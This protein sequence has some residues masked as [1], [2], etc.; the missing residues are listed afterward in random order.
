MRKGGEVYLHSVNRNQIES[1]CKKPTNRSVSE[2]GN[3]NIN[4]SKN[5]KQI[6]LRG[7]E[8]QS[9][10]SFQINR[11]YFSRLIVGSCLKDIAF[12]GEKKST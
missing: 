5:K 9:A 11:I 7:A 8:S 6:Y 1:L 10:S 2:L 3:N 12:R 4:N